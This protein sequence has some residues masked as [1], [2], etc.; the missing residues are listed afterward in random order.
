MMLQTTAITSSSNEHTV[1]AQ[2]PLSNHNNSYIAQRNH[3]NVTAQTSVYGRASLGRGTIAKLH[4]KHAVSL[5]HVSPQTHRNPH[6][7]TKKHHLALIVVSPAHHYA[8]A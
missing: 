2:K 7:A 3:L 1:I 5:R 8:A 6:T 4:E